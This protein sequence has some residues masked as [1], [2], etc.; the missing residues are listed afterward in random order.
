MPEMFGDQVHFR[1]PGMPDKAGISSFMDMPNTR[2]L[3]LNI[4]ALEAKYARA[5]E[6]LVANFAFFLGASNDN[7]DDIRRLPVGAACGIK[8]FMGAST[9]NML[10]DSTD[11]LERIFAEAP[12]LI[13][14]R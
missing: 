8:V 14:N 5:A 4:D 6:C 12:A 13:A 3:A 1:E 11:V 7:L 2:L 9:G 10:L